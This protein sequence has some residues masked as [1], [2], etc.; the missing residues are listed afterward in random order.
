VCL[1]LPGNKIDS[2]DLPYMVKDNTSR[3]GTAFTV[4]IDAATGITTGVSARDRLTTVHAAIADNA[5]PEDLIR[6]GHMFPLRAEDGGV[7][8]RPGH[9]EATV[10]LMR[11]AGLKP[12]GVLAELTNPDGT[13]ARLPEIV[14]FAEYHRMPVVNTDELV[15]YRE[16]LGTGQY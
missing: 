7:L 15:S 8:T 3:F 11:L 16:T 6:P 2:L 4:S 12:Y 14:T 10:D 1:C 13:M 9:T 5:K